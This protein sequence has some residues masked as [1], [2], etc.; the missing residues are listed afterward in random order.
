MS[1]LRRFA[2]EA[3]KIGIGEP[4]REEGTGDADDDSPT[5]ERKYAAPVIRQREHDALD[6]ETQDYGTPE[7]GG[8]ALL[9]GGGRSHDRLTVIRAFERSFA[10]TISS[11]AP[12]GSAIDAPLTV[13]ADLPDEVLQEMTKKMIFRTFE[14]GEVIL[15]EGALGDSCFVIIG[16]AVRV[17]KQDSQRLH[18]PPIEVAR[19]GDGG[20]FGEF[21]ALSDRR[22]HATVEAVTECQIYEIPRPVLRELVASFPGVKPILNSYYRER[23]LATL[24]RT[25]PLFRL[26]PEDSRGH[27]LSMFEPHLCDVGDVLIDEGEPSTGLHLI[28]RGAVDVTKRFVHKENIR[29]ATLSEGDYFGEISLLEGTEAYASVVPTGPTELAVLRPKGF[30]DI[31]STNPSLWDALK[32]EAARRTEVMERMLAN[33][34]A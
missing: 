26:L 16:G 6:D 12:D 7:E 4:N 34:C 24:L 1:V 31:V 19:L 23:L 21:G 10:R 18:S 9:G 32:R 13:F 30:Y 3:T 27:L 33:H 5:G 20:L 14:P 11:L 22:R 2:N 17:L 15:E 28:I 8:T 29:L 25:A